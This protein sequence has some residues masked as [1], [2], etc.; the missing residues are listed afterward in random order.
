MIIYSVDGWRFQ[1]EKKLWQWNPAQLLH[2]TNRVRS[3]QNTEA[4][5][6]FMHVSDMV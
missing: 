1:N 4:L 5:T 2:M 3:K 6:V